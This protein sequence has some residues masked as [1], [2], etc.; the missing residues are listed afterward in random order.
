MTC[1]ITIDFRYRNRLAPPPAERTHSEAVTWGE[2]RPQALLWIS[3]KIYKHGDTGECPAVMKKLI[4]GDV[5]PSLSSG[6]KEYD[7]NYIYSTSLQLD[8]ERLTHKIDQRVVVGFQ[9][10]AHSRNQDGDTY[11]APSGVALIDFTRLWKTRNSNNWHSLPLYEHVDTP[12]PKDHLS[13][14]AHDSD[15]DSD[16]EEEKKGE[17]RVEEKQ[18]L[19]V[20]PEY[21]LPPH[22]FLKGELDIRINMRQPTKLP[23]FVKVRHNSSVPS[24][25]LMRERMRDIIFHSMD[26]MYNSSLRP[27]SPTIE[28][29]QCPTYAGVRMPVPGGAWSMVL[30]PVKASSLEA[31]SMRVK[32]LER[33]LQVAI[34]YRNWTEE[35]FIKVVEEQLA[36]TRENRLIPGF[37][38]ACEILAYA[39]VFFSNS[40][41][42]TDDVLDNRRWTIDRGGK[43]MFISPT[44]SATAN[45]S[46]SKPTTVTADK[47]MDIRKL[48]G[49]DCDDLGHAAS[50]LFWELTRADLGPSP[51]HVVMVA[52]KMAAM[53]YMDFMPH[54]KVSTA[55][56]S[57][58]QQ[59]LKQ[60]IQQGS[61]EADQP[62]IN[63]ICGILL[64]TASVLRW[65]KKGLT[66]VTGKQHSHRQKL[67]A[68]LSKRLIYFDEKSAE[69]R[70]WLYSVQPMALEG[71]G[72]L[73]PC[74]LPRQLWPDEPSIQAQRE[75]QKE[76]MAS[77][78]RKEL[79][80]EIEDIKNLKRPLNRPN[81]GY[82]EEDMRAHPTQQ[83]FYKIVVGCFSYELLEQPYGLH[84]VPPEERYT[85]SCH[86]IS[87]RS[88]GRPEEKGEA[89]SN[90]W[91]WGVGIN[92]LV[93]S[94]IDQTTFDSIALVPDITL[95]RSELHILLDVIHEEPP[96]PL[97][98][99]PPLSGCES[100]AGWRREQHM[101]D[102]IKRVIEDN[103]PPLPESPSTSPQL[104]LSSPVS[105]F[106]TRA[107]LAHEDLLEI[108][109]LPTQVKK[110]RVIGAQLIE[111][112]SLTSSLEP[113]KAH[114][115]LAEF[116]LY[117]QFDIENITRM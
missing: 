65:W 14:E 1:E 61:S 48:F 90:E 40:L 108:I 36:I 96:V 104:A 77:T 24:Y 71:T 17:R 68:Q 74:M 81:E 37:T 116:R 62:G 83:P 109:L 66:L 58:Q 46:E 42:Y 51:P 18:L 107:H 22:T 95:S 19:A 41:P 98:R 56:A 25:S 44:G 110:T 101:L 87:K 16:T 8:S 100:H 33:F 73:P 54:E 6:Y 64:P 32:V 52:R 78:L 10:Y 26:G 69:F 102:Q 53:C 5:L 103:Y 2:Y 11:H 70:P 13:A 115:T 60:K 106:L 21:A 49:G 50:V 47:Y 59:Q 112:F 57:Q 80:K 117:L 82:D 63:H 27:L 75:G 31:R 84:D 30:P 85:V 97:L 43:L 72:L 111:Y 99:F 7:E 55:S 35:Q 28:S 86:F 15:P 20:Y 34:Q 105:Y 3:S 45:I 38:Q 94:G 23:P 29:I 67:P 91:S 4:H 89:N 79:E 93:Y 88:M 92:S 76:A 114:A 12:C 9:V 113:E 39:M